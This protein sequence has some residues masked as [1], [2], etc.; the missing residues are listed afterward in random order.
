M[1]PAL[2]ACDDAPHNILHCLLQDRVTD[3]RV[4][5]TFQGL[6]EIMSGRDPDALDEVHEAL[7]QAEEARMLEQLLE[8]ES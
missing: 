6:D 5:L 3:H 4:G 2:G 8:S 7:R 1:L